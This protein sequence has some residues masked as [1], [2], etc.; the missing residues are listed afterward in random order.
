MYSTIIM[1]LIFK[2]ITDMKCNSILA[3]KIF[4]SVYMELPWLRC[5]DVGIFQENRLDLYII[6]STKQFL[7]RCMCKLSIVFQRFSV[8]NMTLLFNY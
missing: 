1:K 4:W 7:F 5:S 2:V 3:A 6:E 8:T